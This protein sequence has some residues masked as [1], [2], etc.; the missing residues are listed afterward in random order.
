MP[1]SSIL[2]ISLSGG[3]A[4]YGFVKQQSPDGI[5]ASASILSSSRPLEP[6][7]GT[8]AWSSSAPGA[9]PTIQI[10]A[11]GTPRKPTYLRPRDAQSCF[12]ASVLGPIRGSIFDTGREARRA[13]FRCNVVRYDPYGRSYP[14]QTCVR[15]LPSTRSVLK[16]R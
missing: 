7:K 9:S 4:L 8:P 15:E 11:V 12:N 1:V 2:S 14:R 10:G 13:A 6:T 3:L 5:P 16:A